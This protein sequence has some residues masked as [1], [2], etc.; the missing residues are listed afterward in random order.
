MECAAGRRG[1]GCARGRRLKAPASRIGYGTLRHRRHAPRQHAFRYRVA[2]AWLALDELPTLMAGTRLVSASHAAP[3]AFRDSDHLPAAVHD[4]ADGPLEERVRAACQRE[5]ARSGDHAPLPQGRIFLLTQLRH[6]GIGF[7][8]IRLYYLYHASGQ[9][10]AVLGEVTNIPWGERVLYAA[11]TAP[12]RR[13]QAAQFDKRMHVSPFMPMGMR[14]HWRFN[15]P[16]ADELL[17]HI[18]NH[19]LTGDTARKAQ[20]SLFDASL[21]LH[22]EPATPRAFHRLLLRFPWMT[23]KTVAGIHFEALRLALKRV[24]IFDHPR[25]PSSS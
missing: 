10:G 20:H 11:R 6:F 16:S 3:L 12:Q 5:L 14:Y 23:L 21:S 22:L 9:L 24:P 8:P 1:T 2:M 25:S 4:I 7:N 13:M 18:E 17:L 19:P 15:D